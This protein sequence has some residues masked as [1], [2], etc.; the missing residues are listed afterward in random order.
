MHICAFMPVRVYVVVWVLRVCGC[1]YECG[2]ECVCMLERNFFL[3][4]IDNKRYLFSVELRTSVAK[5]KIACFLQWHEL[6]LGDVWI[7]VCIHYTS[8]VLY[9]SFSIPFICSFITFIHIS[10]TNFLLHQNAL[11]QIDFSRI[12][13]IP[14]LFIVSCYFHVFWFVAGIVLWRSFID[15]AINWNSAFY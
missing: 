12:S 9:V 4:Y 11:Y 1:E 3:H 15:Q 2:C 6:M 8:I 5:F 7:R 14:V 10:K 13:K